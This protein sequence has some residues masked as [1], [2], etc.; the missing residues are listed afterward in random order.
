MNDLDERLV[1]LAGSVS[2]GSTVAWESEEQAGLS[3]GLEGLRTLSQVAEAFATQ[4][5]RPQ[6]T[7]I[8]FRWGPLEILEKLA[9]GQFGEVFR[10]WDPQVG[11]EVAL[12]LS[13]GRGSL[14]RP[15]LAEAQR[16]ARVRHPNVVTVFGAAVNQERAGIW[17][18]L[19]PGKTLEQRLEEDGPLGAS[20]LVAVGS[21]LCR[22]L[23]AVHGEGL[24]HG[25]IK[26]SNVVRNEDGRPVLVDFGAAHAPA[27]GQRVMPQ[28]T[29]GYL[30]PEVAVGGASTPASDLFALGA[31]LFRMATGRHRSAGARRTLRDL[32]PDLPSELVA[33]IDSLLAKRPTERPVS[34]GHAERQLLQHRSERIE[35]EPRTQRWRWF[36]AAISVLL[37]AV[38]VF[39]WW[40]F[41]LPPS[42]ADGTVRASLWGRRTG[43]QV[44]LANGSSVQAGDRLNLRVE[45]D[46]PTHVYVFNEDEKGNLFVL[47]PLPGLQPANPLGPGIHLLPGVLDGAEQ[48]WRV[49]SAGGK[50]LFLI[51]GS[52]AIVPRL[53]HFQETHRRAHHDRP[54]EAPVVGRSAET[55]RGVGGVQASVASG[56]SVL[57]QLHADLLLDPAAPRWVEIL[58]LDNPS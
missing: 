7:D 39:G 35:P 4:Q 6:E 41:N 44:R 27:E 17:T 5:S 20:E 53:E 32:R 19:L 10:A 42:P 48:S 45:L 3:A 57:G 24:V 16:L 8:L 47:F 2:D 46:E 29:A 56:E 22:A 12:K 49:T 9:A 58:V 37:L 43:S 52:D 23:A 28:G 40:R 36:S 25:D 11:R 15:W 34:A 51:V 55:L 30:A 54:I 21:E 31:L 18:D 50:E 1:E 14:A 26:T 13:R 38:A 33:T